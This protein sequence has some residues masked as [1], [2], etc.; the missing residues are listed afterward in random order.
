[1]IWRLLA[2]RDAAD[3]ADWI[4]LGGEYV[5]D[6]TEAMG[7]RAPGL[8]RRLADAT[9]ATRAGRTAVRPAVARLVAADLLADAAFAGPFCE[10]TP[11]WYELAL[12]GPNALAS[13]RLRRVAR[14]YAAR[15]DHVP[16]P[17]FSR[18]RDH[19]LDGRPAIAA[20]DGFR[21]RFVLADAVLHLEWYVHVAREAGVTVPESL[22]ARTRNASLAYYA[23]RQAALPADVARFQYHLFGDADWVRRIDAAYGLDSALFGLWERLLA[24]AR[25]DLAAEA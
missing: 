25:A 10:W 17:R 3:F 4:R 6:V 11:T 21:D 5:R 13:R 23:G 7:F 1:M 15:L 8:D 22:V 24:D 18:P 16:V 19:L 20:V 14:P 9:A 2:L 12:A